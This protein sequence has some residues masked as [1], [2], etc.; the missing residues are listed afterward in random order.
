[1]T[2]RAVAA[3]EGRGGGGALP[4]AAVGLVLLV[5]VGLPFLFLLLSSV[6]PSGFPLSD[7]WTL[8]HYE[9]V[10]ADPGY[11]RLLGTTAV[12]AL[13]SVAVAMLLATALVWLVE[14]TDMPLRGLVRALVI[15]PIAV[16][17]VLL[18]IGWTMLLS[19]RIGF[20]NGLLQDL[21]GLEQAPFDIYSLPGMIFV[22]G[23]SLVPPAFLLLSPAF[24]NMD[25]G[26][27]EAALASGASL[28]QLLRR[29]LLPLLAPAILA[30]AI[31]LA[32]A[33][34]IVFD[35]PGTL[36]VP[37]GLHVV[38]TRV[39]YLT[40]HN[41][42]G[43]PAY[44]TVSAMSAFFVVL[45][46]LLAYAYQ[47]ATR[48]AGAFTTISGKGYRPRPFRL[49]H[50]RW[51]ALTLPLAYVLLAVVAPVGMLLWMSLTPYQMAVSASA[52]EQLT[53]RNHAHF[54]AN[55]LTTDATINSV[56]I[57]VLAAS[58]VAALSLAVSWIV[59]RSRLP[60][61][62]L[63]DLV[64]FLPIAIP[65]TIVGVTL[66]YVYLTITVVPI[67]G[68]IWIIV[69]AYVTVFLSFGTRTTN[70]VMMQIHPDLEE[71]GATSGATRLQVVR[72]ILLPLLVPAL[73]VVWVWVLAI[74]MR[75]LSAA[76]MLQGLN[77]A[78]LPTVLWDYWVGGEPNKAAAVGVWLVAA[79]LLVVALWQVLGAWSRRRSSAL[80]S[81]S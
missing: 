74:A 76:L 81:G 17:P 75:E 25:A 4:L 53:L 46:L 20:L 13:G 28:W 19:P 24:R 60:G 58:A 78:T 43:L 26:L 1:M 61:R 80:G 57:A 55:G 42:V 69:L 7:G 9:K 10:Y 11:W 22:E 56:L 31:F 37:A 12:F 54:L 67:Y 52:V 48:R 14:R 45:L 38:A 66:I 63:V 23:L 21:L 30:T 47:R 49:G 72:R 50:W 16:P 79:L 6:K 34:L 68:S 18:A 3:R 36:G 73:V 32:I 2:A 41:P 29:I 71:A 70:S 39:Y 15:L 27:E 64:A 65:G 35:I 5:L 77:N 51:A 8:A 44:G 33:A 62:R 40:H 59:V